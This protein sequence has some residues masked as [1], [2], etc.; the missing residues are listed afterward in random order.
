[1]RDKI[2]ITLTGGWQTQYK[3][4]GDRLRS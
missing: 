2:A 3:S 4:I 1:V